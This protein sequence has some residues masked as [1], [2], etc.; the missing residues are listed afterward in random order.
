MVT[1]SSRLGGWS[2]CSVFLIKRSWR[3]LAE[4]FR[5]KAPGRE[6]D[7]ISSS[8]SRLEALFAIVIVLGL[9]IA[10]RV[11]LIGGQPWFVAACVSACLLM[12]GRRHGTSNGAKSENFDRFRALSEATGDLVMEHDSSGRVLS[13]ACE[14]RPHLQIDAQN[15]LGTGFY[16]R[17]HVADRPKFLHALASAADGGETAPVSLRLRSGAVQRSAGFDEPVFVW[18][19]ARLL[20]IPRRLEAESRRE[21][22]ILSVTRDV[23]GVG[24]VEQRLESARAETALALS[25]KDRLL[26]NVSHELR[27]PLNAILGFSEILAD[28][29]LAP[30]EPAKRVEYA[31]IIHSSAEHLLSVV[32]LVLDMSKIEAGKF[33]ILPEPFELEPLVKDCCDMLR[34][35]AEN[36]KVALLRAES[37]FLLEVVADKRACRQILLNLLSNAVKFTPPEGRVT[38]GAFVVDSM[39][40]IHVSDTGIGIAAQDLPRLGEPFYQVRSNYDRGYEGAGLGL[41]LVRGL[42]GLHGGTIC[43]ESSPGVGTRVTVKLPVDCR[44]A[45]KAGAEPSRLQTFASVSA[46]VEPDPAPIFGSSAFPPEERKIA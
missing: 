29:Q 4:L 41:S 34:L 27:T 25:M 21:A 23:S 22:V 31:A 17:I 35:K 7:L 45:V 37:D 42:V 10:E 30:S 33:Q 6:S 8:P 9:V 11:G 1:P 36:G 39:I 44:S 18:M 19:E 13:I 2:F 40:H 14:A 32:N 5:P 26:A 3:R 43:L 46:S 15:L 12:I 24:E 16:D 28:I 20:G 38:V